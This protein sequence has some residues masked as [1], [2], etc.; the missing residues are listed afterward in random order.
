[1][2]PAYVLCA[3]IRYPLGWPGPR[4]VSGGI[5]TLACDD[6]ASR[7]EKGTAIFDDQMRPKPAFQAILDVGAGKNAATQP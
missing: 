7:I 3:L 5:W 2:P 1:M 4:H 6:D